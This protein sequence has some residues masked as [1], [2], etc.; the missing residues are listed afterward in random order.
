MNA[1]PGRRCPVVVASA[2]SLRLLAFCGR[3]ENSDVFAPIFDGTPLADWRAI[4]QQG[5]QAA[6]SVV[7]GSIQRRG[8]RG[9]CLTWSIPVM[10]TWVISS[11]SSATG[12]WPRGIPESE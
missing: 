11:S 1:C 12:C 6:W 7:D 2:L 5:L 3:T 4:P 9:D 8:L 10:R